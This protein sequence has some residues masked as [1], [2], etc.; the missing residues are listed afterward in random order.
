MKTMKNE[1]YQ[2]HY[3]TQTLD[4]GL[5]VV[6][7][8]KPGYAK[9][10]FLFVTPFGAIHSNMLSEDDQVITFTDGLAH[11]LEHKMFESETG[12]VLSQYSQMG[13][14]ANAFT[15]YYETAY[16]FS[17]TMEIEKPLRLLLDFVQKLEIDEASVEKEKGIIIQELKM[18]QQ[19]SDVRFVQEMFSSLYHLHPLKNDIGGTVESVSSITLEQLKDCF[20]INYHPQNMMLV[21]VSGQEPQEILGIIVSDQRD[22]VF[23]DVVRVKKY[24]YDE[25][26]E[27]VRP[28]YSFSMDVNQTRYGLG[29]K[30]DG[31]EEP[32]KRFRLD[33]ALK[34][35]L[36]GTYS[37]AGKYAQKWLDARY[38]NDSFNYDSDIGEDYGFVFMYSETNVID[39]LDEVFLS[40]LEA[41]KKE[42]IR[43]EEM[44]SI[45]RKL[46]GYYIRTMNRFEDY[47]ISYAR[48]A[49]RGLDY[50]EMI[51]SIKAISLQD[52]REAADLIDINRIA[53][54]ELQPKN[55]GNKANT[56][57]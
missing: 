23:P 53:R 19:M 40:S 9:S 21:G 55:G 47:A 11:F 29:L 8:H 26:H 36:E 7:I 46:T 22:K 51:E 6:L 30:L 43:E 12:D 57:E 4:N 35:L 32:M 33:M 31:I 52:L 18:Y 37:S 15:S 10:H 50:F 28:N 42:L 20:A 13:I 39:K 44:A 38:I 49:L 56:D 1:A 45:K 16:Y 25:P 2:E 5:R 3:H 14:S 34:I 27:V 17:T 24:Q 54:V 41:M 48:A